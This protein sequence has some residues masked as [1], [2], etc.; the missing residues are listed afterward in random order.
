M[1]VLQLIA[2]AGGLGEFAKGKDVLIIRETPPRPAVPARS[3][4]RSS[5]TT[6]RSRRC[7]NL[8]SNIELKPGD[9]VIVP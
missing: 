2:M 1:T 8:G 7:R 5:S 3:R 4:R 9:T 6:T